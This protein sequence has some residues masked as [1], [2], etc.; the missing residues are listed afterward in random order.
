MKKLTLTLRIACAVAAL[1]VARLEESHAQFPAASGIAP[2]DVI[3]RDNTLGWLKFDPTTDQLSSLPWTVT[4]S[5]ST[6]R[7]LFD[8]DGSL[9]HFHI[10]FGGAL[11]HRIN[12][13]TGV[14]Q[15]FGPTVL[16]AGDMAIQP[17]GDFII[18]QM[19]SSASNNGTT[20]SGG[21]D[22]RLLHYSRQS[23]ELTPIPKPAQFS[24]SAVALGPGDTAFAIDSFRHLVSVDLTSGA[25]V[26]LDSSR[27]TLV[28]LSSFPNGDAAY[29][30][31]FDGLT[32]RNAAG[33][34][35]PVGTG[36]GF[37]SFAINE[38]GDVWLARSGQLHFIDG[39]T[40]TMT[41][42]LPTTAQFAPREMVV[43]PANWT[44]PGVP[45]PTSLTLSLGAA[46]IA[47]CLRRRVCEAVAF[48]R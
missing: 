20:W 31:V 29:Y 30:D 37:S 26:D 24:P 9:L 39:A 33:T 15:P 1:F 12:P 35:S 16:R 45:E 28:A 34:E 5:P 42:R 27:Q 17:N 25:V 11:T 43:V 13:V 2:G 44:P 48:T 4:G 36:R 8:V 41:Q 32:R 10:G 21:A 47:G 38:A 46:M 18:A 3:M 14:S 19:A 22:G 40:V 6:E 23:G 7:I